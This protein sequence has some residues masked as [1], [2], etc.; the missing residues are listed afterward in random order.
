MSGFLILFGNL[1]D[2]LKIEIFIMLKVITKRK[3]KKKYF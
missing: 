1:F 2:F 3:L